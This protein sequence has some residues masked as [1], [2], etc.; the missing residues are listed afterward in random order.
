VSAGLDELEALL[1]ANPAVQAEV[2]KLLPTLR[3]MTVNSF[4]ALSI[5]M[6]WENERRTEH[7]RRPVGI[8]N[9]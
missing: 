9:R 2:E 5:A 8:G 3:R 6:R 7:L 1:L 4:V